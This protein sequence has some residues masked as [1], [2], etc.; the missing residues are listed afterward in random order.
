MVSGRVS[1]Q[2]AGTGALQKREY[3]SIPTLFIDLWNGSGNHQNSDQ[4]SGNR[5]RPVFTAFDF[6]ALF[7][8]SFSLAEI[9]TGFTKGSKRTLR[10]CL[11]I[12]STFKRHTSKPHV[13]A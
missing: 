5:L 4:H 12:D 6:T 9:Q 8:T 13:P 7:Y 11:P 1:S 2:L 10:V 3:Q